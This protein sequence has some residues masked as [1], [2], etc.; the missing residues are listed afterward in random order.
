VQPFTSNGIQATQYQVNAQQGTGGVVTGPPTDPLSPGWGAAWNP[1]GVERIN[2]LLVPNPTR[3]GVFW[4][5]PNFR[6]PYTDRLT[7]GFEREIFSKTA[8][9]M[10]LVYAKGHQLQRLTDINRQYDGTTSTNG[11]PHYATS[12]TAKPYPFYGT[13]LTSKSD[14]TA[15]YYA[16]TFH[17][18]RHFSNSFSMNAGLTWSRDYDND[19]NER[20]FA[21]IQAEDY[22]NLDLNWGP[23]ARDQT[24]KGSVSAVWDTPF[25]GLGLS[26]SYSYNTG[27][28]R[29]P[30]INSD[31]NG[32]G[33]TS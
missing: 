31:V 33:V 12:N 21:G 22:N 27:S 24:W 6:N 16:A 4:V 1:V 20:N 13:I 2:F 7:L 9:S 10:E 23:S 11:L 5:D 26:G 25:W 19:S 30:I 14:A 17:V 32:D 29:N 15:L 8:A 28:T 18:Q 3:P